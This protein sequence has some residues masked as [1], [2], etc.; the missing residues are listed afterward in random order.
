MTDTTRPTLTKY[1]P[2]EKLR[3]PQLGGPVTFEYCRKMNMG[4]PCHQLYK[5]W[6]EELDI[7]EYV[8]SNFTQEEIDKVFNTPPPGR[9]GTIF[10]VLQR[11]EKMKESG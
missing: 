6:E 9:V 5:C 1:D 3:C 8:K 4:L 11:V 10:D 2:I 7:D